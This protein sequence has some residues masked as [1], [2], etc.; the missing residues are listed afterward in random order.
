ML[1]A[2]SHSS[3]RWLGI[4]P[5][6]LEEAG[7]GHLL[8]PAVL[9]AFIDMQQDARQ[10]GIDLQLVSSYRS[11]ERQ[12][13]IWNRKWR[14]EAK[15]LDINGVPLNPERLSNVEKLHAIL[16]WSALPAAVATIGGLILTFMTKQQYPNG[17]A[18]F[19][20]LKRNM[21]LMVPAIRWRSG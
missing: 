1:T 8:L 12:C 11:F 14:G 9:D 21:L 5:H 4:S 16:M 20:W 6:Q 2:P 13:L 17:M 10:A 18:I 15:L 7:N 3:S 19:N